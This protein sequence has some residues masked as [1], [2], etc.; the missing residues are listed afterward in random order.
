VAEAQAA[1]KAEL[2]HQA[3]DI[4]RDAAAALERIANAR[5]ADAIAR[6]VL[7]LPARK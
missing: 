2:P 1:L 5:L 6:V 7:G 3:D 4:D